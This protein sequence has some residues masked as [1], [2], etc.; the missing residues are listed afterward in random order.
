MKK[1]YLSIVILVSFQLLTAQSFKGKSDKKFQFGANIQSR[2]VG[3]SSSFD[4]GLGE[5]LSFGLMANYLINADEALNEKAKFS[6]RTDLKARFNAHLGD[7]IGLPSVIDVYPGLSLGTKNFGGHV[8]IRYFF[9]DGFGV[10]SEATF[11]IARYDSSVIG[12]ERYNNQF[13][14]LLGASFNL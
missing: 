4:L 8:G 14:L 12:V 5:N 7:V 11:P 1:N 2:A 3:V 13:A 6:D 10:Y 9:S